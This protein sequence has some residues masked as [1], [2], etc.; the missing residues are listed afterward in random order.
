[1]MFPFVDLALKYVK[2]VKGPVRNPLPP[3]VPPDA[4]PSLTVTIMR[5]ENVQLPSTKTRSASPT[6]HWERE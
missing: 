6:L 4:R 2:R 1:M 3:T 5:D